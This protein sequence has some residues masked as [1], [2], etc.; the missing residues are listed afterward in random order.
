MTGIPTPTVSPEVS[1]SEALKVAAG[2]DVSNV[3]VR[4]DV[5]PRSLIAVALTA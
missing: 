1:P 3:A 4:V 2:A 5:L